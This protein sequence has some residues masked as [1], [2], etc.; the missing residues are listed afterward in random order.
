MP[1]I[2]K[3]FDW[4]CSKMC[5]LNY[6]CCNKT[7]LFAIGCSTFAAPILVVLYDK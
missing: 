6:F 5:K 4:Y 7:P 1:L 2:T 3:A